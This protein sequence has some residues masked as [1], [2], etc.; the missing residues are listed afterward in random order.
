MDDLMQ[1][2]IAPLKHNTV[3]HITDAGQMNT[4]FAVSTISYC[5]LWQDNT[6]LFVDYPLLYNLAQYVEF[7]DK[8]YEEI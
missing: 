8:T 7:V 1:P 4:G 5:F 2:D 6:V 3:L